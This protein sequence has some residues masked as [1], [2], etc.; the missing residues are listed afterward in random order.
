MAAAV[1]FVTV[2]SMIVTMAMFGQLGQA[3]DW[4]PTYITTKDF[5]TL[6][7]TIDGEKEGTMISKKSWFIKFYAPWCKHCQSFAPIWSEFNK[8]H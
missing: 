2:L 1:K 5:T 6:I 4:E 3:Q 7:A 8:K